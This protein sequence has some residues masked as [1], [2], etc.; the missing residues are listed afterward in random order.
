MEL[1][2]GSIRTSVMSSSSKLP[3][4]FAL[5]LTQIA[6]SQSP[7]KPVL[8]VED[9]TPK[10]L[11]FFQ[12]AGKEQADEQQ[13][14]ALWQKMYGFAAVPPTPDGQQMARK[15]LDDAWPKY[16]KALPTIE[17]G[18]ANLQPPPL[19]TLDAVADLL[20]VDVRIRV[21]LLLFVGGF[22]NNA[23]T[24]PGKNGVPTVALPV[25]GQGSTMVLTHELTHVV[26]AEQANLSLD[27]KRSVAHTIFT[28]GLAMRVT[29]RIHP[30]QPDKEYVGEF[31]PNWFA[32]AE[33]TRAAILADI[34][35]HLAESDSS[36][37]MRYTMGTGGAGIEREAYLAGWLV[38]G[39]LLAHG[40]TF[41]RLARVTDEEMTTLVA[42]T[43]RRLKTEGSPQLLPKS[44]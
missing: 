2:P 37:I 41:P 43:L 10:F 4:T 12:A 40:W 44:N 5:A 16:P 9:L 31:T 33:Q 27:W 7:P 28:E 17:R 35:P 1:R 24:S 39:D 18:I 34:A 3:S 14:W 13:R 30:G 6:F 26:E 11:T 22:D 23:F 42:E 36:A 32:R 25:E 20:Q 29:Q 8:T 21:H 38:I 15:I 19:E